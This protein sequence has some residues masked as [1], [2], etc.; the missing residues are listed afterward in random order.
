MKPYRILVTGSRDWTD[1]DALNNAL[2]DVV[3]PIPAHQEIVIVHGAAKGAD[4]MADQ[5]ARIYG[6]TVEAH[7]A[8]WAKH[9]RKA[10]PIRNAVMVAAGADVCLAFIKNGSAGATYTARLAEKALITVRRFT[11]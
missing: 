10:G 11:A 3:R 1:R 7:P 5:W 6:A 4:T 8:N 9:G 2:A